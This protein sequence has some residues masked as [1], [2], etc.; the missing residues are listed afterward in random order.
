MID[1]SKKLASL[2]V[3]KLRVDAVTA[4]DFSNFI[5][6]GLR[7]KKLL[8]IVKIN[9]EFLHRALTDEKYASVLNSFD[10]HIADGRGV[11]WAARYL[12]LPIS[13]NKF[14]R[15]IQAVCQMVYSGASIVLWPKFV[16]TPLPVVLP[17]VDAFKMLINTA[18][19]QQ[20]DFFLFGSPQ[21]T[22]EP[23]LK[24]IKKSY[25]KLS[26]VGALN[27]YDFWKDSSI[28]PVAIINKS[29]ATVLPVAMG[30]PRQEYWI[31][32]NADKLKN[33]RI[34][35]GEGGTYTRIAFPYQKAPKFINRIGLEWLWRTL[36][37]K[38]ETASRNRFQKFWNAVPKFIYLIVKWK[39]KNGQT[40]VDNYEK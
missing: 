31:N 32:D 24:N 27:G 36:F 39:I 9:T 15:P 2:M 16:T 13:N 40:K 1:R 10:L 34:A 17:G 35:V 8:K 33:V 20:A 26:V 6:D 18:V 37:N 28:D 29:G 25:P 22:L 5:A 21:A 11:Q 4:D 38:S 12:T 30:S 14:L 3:M 19:E 7:G 23:A